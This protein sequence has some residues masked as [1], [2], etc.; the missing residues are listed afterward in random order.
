M[1]AW[2][3]SILVG[4]YQHVLW[5]LMLDLHAT[6]SKHIWISCGR[7]PRPSPGTFPPFPPWILINRL[8]FSSNT[9]LGGNV[10]II[11]VWSFKVK[12]RYFVWFEFENVSISNFHIRK[13]RSPS[14]F[15]FES[16][17]H[18]SIKPSRITQHKV[19]FGIWR[20]F[21]RLRLW[22]ICDW[23]MWLEYI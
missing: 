22:F 1:H 21:L 20:F 6:P 12:R 17:L 4:F 8:C 18:Q 14:F 13:R 16:S 15:L 7:I 2:Y 11:C 19:S 3:R 23:F 9:S 5:T 10:A